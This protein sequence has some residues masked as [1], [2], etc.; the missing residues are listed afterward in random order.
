VS[1]PPTR[2]GR[3]SFTWYHGLLAVAL[4]LIAVMWVYALGFAPQGNPNRLHDT[5]W[6]ANAESVCAAAQQ[7]I[8][9]LPPA[10]TAKSP[11]QRAD[12]VDQADTILSDM[13]A[14]LKAAALSG[15]VKEQHY[16]EMWLADYETYLG[17]RRDWAAI[18][19]QGESKPFAITKADGGPI[20][21]RMDGFS[22]TNGML[23]CKAPLDV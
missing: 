5:A 14:T 18:L 23:S 22:E 20:I 9:A 16:V 1:A 7:Q 6:T 3:R 10:K 2:R 15:T 17:D 21:D 12:V 11:Q 4:V 13:I 8:A 19:H